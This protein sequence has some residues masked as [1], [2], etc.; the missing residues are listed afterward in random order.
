MRRWLQYLGFLAMPC[1]TG[2]GITTGEG[3]V[4]GEAP[5]EVDSETMMLIN[6]DEGLDAA[7][8]RG[9]PLST[10]SMELVPGVFGSAARA[11]PGAIE[12]DHL[13]AAPF[14]RM[15]RCRHD[16]NF[17]VEQGTLEM[18]V[19]PHFG[20][21]ENLGEATLPHMGNDYYLFHFAIS[22]GHRDV[23]LFLREWVDERDGLSRVVGFRDRT[24]RRTADTRQMFSPKDILQP[25]EWHHIAVTWGD[26]GRTL[27]VNGMPVASM[28]HR[29][30]LPAFGPSARPMAVGS[31]AT[32]SS[33]PAWSDI[34]E[35]R[36][37]DSVRYREAFEV[38]VPQ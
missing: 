22:P 34:D 16:D 7:F 13:F 18:W 23:A 3:S 38:E 24:A 33:R 28:D 4:V 5:I 21:V 26:H 30:P 20:N 37:S 17:P 27:F 29:G 31:M 6:F 12:R 14:F 19:R 11:R 10:G 2:C 8:A 36:I 9:S 15:V 1:L 25:G 35:V 32:Y